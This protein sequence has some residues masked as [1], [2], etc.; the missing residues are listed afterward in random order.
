MDGQGVDPRAERDGRAAAEDGRA[1][2]SRA[3]EHLVVVGRFLPRT[4][5]LFIKLTP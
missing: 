2:V 4:L 1:V 3:A 5:L